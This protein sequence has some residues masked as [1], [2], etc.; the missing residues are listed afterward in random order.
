MLA[1]D[2]GYSTGK[3]AHSRNPHLDIRQLEQAAHSW[4]TNQGYTGQD[5]QEAVEG[6]IVGYEDAD[7]EISQIRN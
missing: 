5:W 6:F 2:S 3:E 7:A 4:A 1:Y